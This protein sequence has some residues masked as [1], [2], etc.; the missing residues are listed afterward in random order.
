MKKRICLMNQMKTRLDDIKANPHLL[1]FYAKQQCKKCRGRGV[2]EISVPFGQRWQ[3][4]T[5]L[6]DCVLKSVRREVSEL[7]NG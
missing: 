5:Q 3:A 6:C 7:Q 4:Y 1:E 2:V